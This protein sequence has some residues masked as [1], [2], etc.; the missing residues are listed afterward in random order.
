MH[1]R[2]VLDGRQPEGDGD[3]PAGIRRVV[4]KLRCSLS[5]DIL[6]AGSAVAT[7]LFDQATFF[8]ILKGRWIKSD[9]SLSRES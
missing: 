4:L 9:S 8:L 6:I 1:R 5:V 7:D 3:L 2:K